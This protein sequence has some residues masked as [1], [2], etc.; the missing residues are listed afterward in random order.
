M[1]TASIDHRTRYDHDVVDL[2]PEQFFAEQLPRL[3]ERHGH[4]AGAG[5]EALRARPLA[6]E[7]GAFSMTLGADGRTMS[8]TGGIRDGAVVVTLDPDQFSDW[9]Q[10]IRTFDAM[11]SLGELSWRGSGRRQLAVWDALWIAVLEGWA[12]V[13]PALRFLDREGDPLD[14]SRCFTP[15]D[16]P[17]DVAHFLR[18]T[19]YLHLRGWL[20]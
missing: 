8:A 14:L 17:M 6:I 3:L 10:Q 12:V 9:A 5:F 20:D 1:R 16:D 18:E 4:L 7:V 11:I 15:E 13:D 2:T 19:G